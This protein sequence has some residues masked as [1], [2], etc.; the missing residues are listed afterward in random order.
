MQKWVGS[1]GVCI[2]EKGQLL[3]VLQGKPEE[4]KKWSVPSG[5]LE[6]NE[7]LEECCIREVEEETGYRVEIV[8][9]IKLKKGSYEE[10]QISFE[11]HYFLVKIVG[12][13]RKIQ[14]PDHLIYDIAWKDIDELRTIDFSFPEDKD[15]LIGLLTKAVAATSHHK[16]CEK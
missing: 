10:I 2:S 15:F 11:V 13:E 4:E 1:A 8:D 6:K 14:D 3:M 7:T 12:G 9:E 5:G 16:E